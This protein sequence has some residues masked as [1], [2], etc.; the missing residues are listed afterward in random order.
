MKTT[1][2]GDAL[3]LLLI[4]AFACISHFAS[5]RTHGQDLAVTTGSTAATTAE[6]AAGFDMSDYDPRYRSGGKARAFFEG[7]EVGV[8]E[9]VAEWDRGR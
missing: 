7:T 2:H 8:I 4:L 6:R 3:T 9:R 1:P 5:G